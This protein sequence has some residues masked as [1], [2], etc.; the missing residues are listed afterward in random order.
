MMYEVRGK[1]EEVRVKSLLYIQNIE[2]ISLFVQIFW[3]FLADNG[4]KLYLCSRKC[5]KNLP[6]GDDG[7]YFC[8]AVCREIRRLGTHGS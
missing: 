1:R 3:V 5:G 4:K 8:D 6:I 7:I 2:T